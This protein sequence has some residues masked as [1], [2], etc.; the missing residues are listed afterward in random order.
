MIYAIM[1]GLTVGAVLYLISVGFSLTFGTMRVINFAHTITYTL[2]AYLLIASIRS[3]GVPFFWGGAV[4]V[5]V[6]ALAG[7]GIERFVIRRLYGESLDYTF[8]A[9]YAVFLIG[10]DIVK[11]LWGV[12]PKPVSDPL[13]KTVDILGF[14]FP[15]YRILV[16]L[17]AIVVFFGLE[18]FMRKTMVGKIIVAAL[19]NREGVRCLG[20]GVEKY[21]SLAFVLGSALAALGGVLY[22]PIT[23]VHP[24]MG[25]HILL[26]C[27]AVVL[28]G[29]LGNLRGTFLASFAL[30]MLI[31]I[32]GR[33]WP[34]GS[35][36]VAFIA[37]A[38]VLLARPIEA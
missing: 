25:S 2:G 19:D 15:T 9:T 30:G 10:V 37:M 29:G 36:I 26:L 21:F 28:T 1:Y 35:E 33:Y 24:Y 8:I 13:G 38:A 18:L 5:A 23:A 20:I 11:W 27:F 32:T 31:S 7:Y 3:L 12:F 14:V 22:A 34:A 17:L 6:A 16:V 4:G